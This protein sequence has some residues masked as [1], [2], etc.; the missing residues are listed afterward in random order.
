VNEVVDAIVGFTSVGQV[1]AP[2]SRIIAHPTGLTDR[3]VDV[4]RL[5][6]QGRTNRDIAD[7]LVLSV[8][9][10]ERHLGNI[11]EKIGASGKAARAAAATF[12]VTNGLG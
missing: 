6:S 3:E 12:A 2:V 9:T 5:I 8:R 10:V 7:E 4:I 11:Y 1:T